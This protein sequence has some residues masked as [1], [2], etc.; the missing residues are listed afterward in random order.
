MEQERTPANFRALLGE[1]PAPAPLALTTLDEQ[2][3]PTHTRRL[4]EYAIETDERVQAYL[5]VPND[6]QPGER[7]PGILAVHQDG[8][9]RPYEFGKSE[10][11]GVAGDPDLAYGRELCERGYVVLCPDR[12]PFES[13]S[14]TASRFAPTFERFRLFRDGGLELTEDLYAGCVANRLLHEG[15]TALGQ[16]LYELQRAIDCLSREQPEVDAGRLG[17]IGHSAGGFYGALLMY[18]DPRLAVGCA[19]CGTFLFRE[20][21]NRAYLRPINGF[22]GLAVPGMGRWGDVDDVLAGLAPRP[23]LETVGDKTTP[24]HLAALTGKARTR[25]AEL[26]VPERYMYRTYDGGHVFRRDMR[27]QSY[28]WFDCWLRAAGCPGVTI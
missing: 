26:G 12:F 9:R 13:R 6:L 20:V 2:V 23:F 8:A 27:E 28:A 14:L 15:R 3:Q 5:L 19:S 18:L 25:Y 1:A 11:A 17:V 10:P 16:C 21:W 22:A 24:E 7:R 4:V